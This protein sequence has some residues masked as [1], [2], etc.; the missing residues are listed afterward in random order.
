MNI[1]QQIIDN[2]RKNQSSITA[3]YKKAEWEMSTTPEHDFDILSTTFTFE[4]GSQ[5]KFTD[6]EVIEVV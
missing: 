4:D 3:L 2:G 5:L 6:N 1:A